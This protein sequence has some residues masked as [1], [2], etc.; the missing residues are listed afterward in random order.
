MI[1]RQLKEKEFINF[2][3]DLIKYAHCYPMEAHIDVDVVFNNQKY[4]LRL[5][6][7]KHCKIVALQAINILHSK[8]ENDYILITDNQILLAMLNLLVYQGIKGHNNY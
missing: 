2:T 8:T 1:S 4:I 3:N 7:D 6:P 5:Q